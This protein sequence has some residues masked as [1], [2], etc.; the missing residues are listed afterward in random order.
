LPPPSLR[1][2]TSGPDCGPVL[3]DSLSRRPAPLSLPADPGQHRGNLLWLS[4]PP[5]RGRGVLLLADCSRTASD[6]FDP[7]EERGMAAYAR[8][9]APAFITMIAIPV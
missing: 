4:A 8:H 3:P 7:G 9:G 5:I 2:I 6:V 1:C